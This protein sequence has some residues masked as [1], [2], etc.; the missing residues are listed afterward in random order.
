M[1]CWASIFKQT[2]HETSR[3]QC[4]GHTKVVAGAWSSQDEKP[5]LTAGA[6]GSA[7]ML[8]A[9]VTE[10]QLAQA[11]AD[12]KILAAEWELD[13]R[14][15]HG[16]E[17]DWMERRLG[18]GEDRAQRLGRG[19]DRAGYGQGEDRTHQLDR[20]EG[21]AADETSSQGEGYD[22]MMMMEDDS[23]PS[24]TPP[25]PMRRRT[26]E[27]TPEAGAGA[28][29]AIATEM[30]ESRQVREILKPEPF[31]GQHADFSEF[32]EGMR[33]F[34]A[35][36]NMEGLLR[37]AGD[38]ATPIALVEQ[39]STVREIGTVIYQ[40][41]RKL[42]H[43]DAKA[44]VRQVQD[45]N[46][47]EAWRLLHQQFV[48]DTGDRHISV[49]QGLLN[50][51]NWS[52][53][54][55]HKF[56]A[57]YT[58]WKHDVAQYEHDAQD[59]VTGATRVA[60]VKK[61]APQPVRQALYLA[62]VG[63]D[64]AKL[65][66]KMRC[67]VDSLISYDASGV[68]IPDEER[69]DDASA[70]MEVGALGKGKGTGKS[71]FGGKGKPS[72]WPAARPTDAPS[73]S[74]LCFRCNQPGHRAAECTQPLAPGQD[75][76]RCDFCE[77]YGHRQKNC[78]YWKKYHDITMK[79]VRRTA[80]AQALTNYDEVPFEDLNSEQLMGLLQ[81]GEISLELYNELL[82]TLAEP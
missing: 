64:F 61:F 35:T 14:E 26:L 46:G 5:E 42:C 45:S 10:T 40:V 39:S 69:E 41:L 17:E 8:H 19:E 73:G 54:P 63:K 27:S 68:P 9:G 4:T 21:Q 80:S 24:L 22:E 2:Q 49:L 36:W 1:T 32:E 66:D 23:G 55:L 60:V 29:P 28:K 65:N 25:T 38:R 43:G 31:S 51:S 77:Q 33:S 62:D 18:R 48:P 78:Q 56:W 12:M 7:F 6:Q 70:P 76:G 34:M 71:K 59:Q 82:P 53:T 16:A 58:Q 72:A 52:D 74:F 11:S 37:H 30:R 3:A 57:V 50:P 81:D 15:A 44:T 13:R 79:Q 20:G 47:W 75:A 67:V